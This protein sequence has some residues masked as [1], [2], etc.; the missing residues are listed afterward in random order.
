MN[1]LSKEEFIAIVIRDL[2]I[3]KHIHSKI[4]PGTENYRPTEKQRSILELLQYLGY[5]YT[6]G[7]EAIVTGDGGAFAKHG[8]EGPNITVENFPSYIDKGIEAVKMSIG[9]MTEEDMQAPLSL[10][11]APE[12]PKK[13]WMMELLLKSVV[14]YKTQLFLYIKAT[15]NDSIG[16]SNLWQGMDSKS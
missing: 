1:M 2:E 6:G 11:G 7:V 5:A 3:L 13:Y 10:F 16:T 12:Q 8:A 15:G 4:L 9:A 14:A